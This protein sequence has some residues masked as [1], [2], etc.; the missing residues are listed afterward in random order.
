M[1]KRILAFALAA[2]ALFMAACSGGGNSNSTGKTEKHVEVWSTYNTAKVV[3]QTAKNGK[4]QQLPAT[5]SVQ[6]MK[7]EYEGAQLIVTSNTEVPYQLLKGELKNENGTAFP[8]KNV[9]IYHQKYIT[10]ARNYNGNPM[11]NAGDSIPDMLLP[12]DTAVECGENTV[13]Q[14]SN[15]GITVEFNSNG[16]EAGTYTGSFVLEIDGEKQNIPVS[17][18]VWD[19]E[20]TGRRT[21]QSSFLIYRDQLL[22]GEYKNDKATVDAYIDFLQDYKIDAYVTRDN[23]E[24]EHFQESV[25]RFEHP[26]AASIVI[27]VDFPLTYKAEESNA[28]FK[29]AVGYITWLAKQ[30]TEENPYIEYAYFYPSTYDEADVVAERGAASAAFF[31]EGGEYEKTLQAAADMLLTDAEFTQKPQELQERILQAVKTIPAVFTNV[32]YN[33]EWVKEFDTAFCPY[34]SLFDDRATLQRYQVAAEENANGDLWAYTCCDPDYPY[35]TFHIDDTALGMRVNGWMNKAYDIDGYLYYSVNKYSMM[36]DENANEYI[37]VYEEPSR[38]PDTNG[39]GFLLYPGKYYGSEKPFAS[40]RLVSYRDGMDDYD[41]LCVYENLLK[42]KAEK[43]GVEF[44]FDDYVADLYYTLFNGMQAYADDSLVY[45]M[46]EELAKRITALKNEDDL[47]VDTSRAKNEKTVNVYTTASNIT[48]NGDSVVGERQ[49]EG[50]RFTLALG[51]EAST[52]AIKVGDN[53]Y[54]Y[55]VGAHTVVSKDAITVSE[56][57]VKEIVGDKAVVTVK[58]IDDPDYRDFLRPAI[59][60][61]VSGLSNVENIRFA[62]ENVGDEEIEIRISLI[63]TSGKVLLSTSYC[64]VGGSREELVHIANAHSVDFS[65]VTAIEISFENVVLT[66][67]GTV[68]ANDRKIAIGDL[69]LDIR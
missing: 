10:I 25:E 8:L 19:I 14:N 39:D 59:T 36:H 31:E 52:L 22:P 54:S 9:A 55:S 6:M 12:M 20:Y 32:H 21:F 27:P 29:E 28:C 17:V 16:V 61:Q 65:S 50:Y 2:S 51:V 30:S 48:V 62:Y 56:G 5:I 37:D 13:A 35:P 45:Q 69:W 7:G 40:L 11:F 57:S 18:E 49:G 68:L 24:A 23:W 46:R 63:T 43:Y 53:E 33:E 3:R 58:A 66:D 42:E 38:Y 60:Y 1:K 67:E 15:Q 47:I 41:M 26:Y 4:Y 44:N 34:I 64:N